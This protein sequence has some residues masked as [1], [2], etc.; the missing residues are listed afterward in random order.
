MSYNFEEEYYQFG[1]RFSDPLEYLKDD[2]SRQSEPR[3]SLEAITRQE[4]I[5]S[6][7]P[8]ENNNL[9][10]KKIFSSVSH[11]MFNDEEDKLYE[12]LEHKYELSE[13]HRHIEDLKD[14]IEM[15]SYLREHVT[16]TNLSREGQSNSEFE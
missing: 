3:S 2:V 10:L 4:E 16:N 9:G 11:N 15:G 5:P 13:E 6:F 7:A 1:S 12:N 14:G 8:L